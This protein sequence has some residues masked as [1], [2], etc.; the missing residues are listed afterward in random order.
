MTFLTRIASA[1][2]PCSYT[3]ES[4]MKT[5]PD[6]VYQEQSLYKLLTGTFPTSRPYSRFSEILYQTPYN[7]SR[8]VYSDIFFIVRCYH[9]FF[10]VYHS[11]LYRHYKSPDSEKK[12][13]RFNHN[14]DA[15][16]FMIMM[17]L[18]TPFSV[19]FMVVVGYILSQPRP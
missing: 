8:N 12:T 11:V 3:R 7:K 13:S 10:C 18:I 5:V 9:L 14:F 6:T 2:V 19:N 16:L 4:T 1:V 15:V 17:K